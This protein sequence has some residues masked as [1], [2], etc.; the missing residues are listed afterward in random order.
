MPQIKRRRASSYG[1]GVRRPYKMPR[2]TLARRR[3]VN[4]RTGGFMGIE[5]KFIDYTLNSGTLTSSWAGAEHNPTTI[6]C[7]SAVAQGDGESSRD[8]RK[9]AVNSVH[10]QGQVS[11]L[12][13]ES[14]TVPAPDIIVKVALVQDTQ[15]NGTELSAENVFS[16]AAATHDVYGFRNLQFVK[17]FKVLAHKW[18]TLPVGQSTTNEGGINLFANNKVSRKWSMN[19]KF[20]EPM[21][22]N[23][24]GTTAVVGSIADNSLHLIACANDNSATT[25]VSYISRCRFTG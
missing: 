22:V 25:T 4:Y 10:L 9:Y 23:C 7:L 21:I 14:E 20:K 1:F 16:D 3:S 8:G 13:A 11:H 15:T 5:N 6:D 17:R 19:Y 2:K 24:T 18:I 12:A